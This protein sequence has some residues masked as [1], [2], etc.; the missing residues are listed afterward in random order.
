[1]AA[2]P[3]TC[4]R[5]A[6]ALSSQT[7]QRLA[8]RAPL[9]PVSQKG[10]G[11]RHGSSR[12]VVARWSCLLGLTLQHTELSSLLSPCAISYLPCSFLNPVG[13]ASPAPLPLPHRM[14]EPQDSGRGQVALP[15]GGGAGTSLGCLPPGPVPFR[16]PHTALSPGNLCSHEAGRGWRRSQHL[17]PTGATRTLPLEANALSVPRKAQVRG[18]LQSTEESKQAHS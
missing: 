8:P 10:S 13:R 1:M 12:W 6:T 17:T 4:S 14:P 5:P 3:L 11:R 2:G 16:G 9:P 15:E 7:S 18:T